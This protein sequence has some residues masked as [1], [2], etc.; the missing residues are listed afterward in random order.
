MR[1]H[2]AEFDFD[3]GLG[4]VVGED[5]VNY[6][7]HCVSIADASRDIAVGATVEFDHL[8]KLGRIEAANIRSL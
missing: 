3:R 7:F 6:P 5:Q 4:V 1:G 2:V 8:M